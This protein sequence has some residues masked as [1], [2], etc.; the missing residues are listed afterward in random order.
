MRSTTMTC[1]TCPQKPLLDE[2]THAGYDT[3][4]SI[5]GQM[6]ATAWG[7]PKGARG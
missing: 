6:V 4:S 5:G 2:K 7:L 1:G 3:T